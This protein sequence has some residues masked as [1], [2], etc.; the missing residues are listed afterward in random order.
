[1]TL[2]LLLI[3]VSRL[4]LFFWIYLSCLTEWTMVL[5]K[6]LICGMGPNYRV[7]AMPASIEHFDENS[8]P[9]V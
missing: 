9:M 7:T 1:M 4:F 6:P 2:L 8:F 5:G 3:M